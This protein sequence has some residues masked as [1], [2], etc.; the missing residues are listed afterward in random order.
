MELLVGAILGVMCSESYR[1]FRSRPRLRIESSFFQK[2][3]DELFNQAGIQAIQAGKKR[4]N[5]G[6]TITVTNEGNARVEDYDIVFKS[7]V[8]TLTVFSTEKT[9]PL[10][11]GQKREHTCITKHHTGTQLKDHLQESRWSSKQ[12]IE[13]ASLQVVMKDSET[14]VCKSERFGQAV[15]QCLCTGEDNMSMYWHKVKPW[16][17]SGWFSDRKNRRMFNRMT[18]D[19]AKKVVEDSEELAS[20]TA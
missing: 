8:G 10:L 6:I 12:A 4:S 20:G 9:G 3:P 13:E 2:I 15:M 11:P 17:I 19:T 7:P 5:E 16:T 14:G 18:K 1:W